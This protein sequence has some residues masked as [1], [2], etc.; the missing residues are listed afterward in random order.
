MERQFSP[1]PFHGGFG[2]HPFFHPF[3][4][5]FFPRRSLFPFFA[6]SP[7]FFPF[8]RGD[9]DSNDMCFAQHQ[10]QEGDTVEKVAH[11]YNIPHSILEEANP[12][13]GNPNQ[14]RVG[15]TVFIPRIS[16]L[17]CHKTYME[18]EMPNTGAPAPMY[19]GQ[20]AMS[21]SGMPNTMYP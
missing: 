8:F 6:L 21:F 13:I 4:H 19:Q 1:P 5:P 16:N 11:M 12:H 3:I 10:A 14:L 20:Q 17:H 15:E 9:G 7:F 2:F 18:Q